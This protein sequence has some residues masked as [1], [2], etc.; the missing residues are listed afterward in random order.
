MFIEFA[1]HQFVKLSNNFMMRSSGRSCLNNLNTFY[2]ICGEYVEKKVK[3]PT[4][5]FVKKAYFDHFKIKIKDLD[6]PW[7]PKIVYKL[8]IEHSR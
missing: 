7:L 2:Y 3:K 6:Q 1:F 5:D 4:S 8:C